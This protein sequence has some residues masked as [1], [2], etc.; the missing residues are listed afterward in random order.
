MIWERLDRGVANYEWLAKFP[1]GKVKHLNCFTSDYRPIILALN[2]DGEQQKWC[3]I[4]FRFEAM[5]ILDPGCR[6]TITKAWDCAPNGTPMFVASQ[7]LKKC[8]KG[9]KAQSRDHFGNVQKSITQ[10]KDQL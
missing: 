2:V 5:Q 9:L 7:K 1:V 3:Q 8:K 4:L 10:L 6:E